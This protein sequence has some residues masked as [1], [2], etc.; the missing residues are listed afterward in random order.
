[1]SNKVENNCHLFLKNNSTQNLYLPTHLQ[2][3]YSN[4]LTDSSSAFIIAQLHSL[5]NN[6]NSKTKNK[7][8]LE[9]KNSNT[10]FSQRNLKEAEQMKKEVELLSNN[11]T[12]QKTVVNY[13]NDSNEMKE[14]NN[15]EL[16]NNCVK[17]INDIRKKVSK[18]NVQHS[19]K[20][21]KKVKSIYNG[22]EQSQGTEEGN[23][24][25]VKK[26][27]KL[28]MQKS[29]KSLCDK[30]NNNDRRIIKESENKNINKKDNK[31][32]DYVKYVNNDRYN[33][34]GNILNMTQIYSQSKYIFNQSK[35]FT[36]IERK[37]SMIDS[38]SNNQKND[39]ECNKSNHNFNY[40][41]YNK[42]KLGFI[43]RK[44]L[45]LLSKEINK[46]EC[47][48]NVNSFVSKNISTSPNSNK[49][50]KNY[51]SN[52]QKNNDLEKSQNKIDKTDDNFKEIKYKSNGSDK[53]NDSNK[54][55]IF[56]IKPTQ[57]TKKS[58]YKKNNEKYQINKDN[59]TIPSSIGS[60]NTKD[61]NKNTLD[62]I[63]DI[64]NKNVDNP[65]EL[66]FLYIKILQ[67]GKEISKKFEIESI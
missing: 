50:T 67:N 3:K 44:E 42:Y 11:K 47:N 5:N 63:S 17:D 39:N 53:N 59:K 62:S 33:V 14:N 40:I 60:T 48:N 52:M 56:F 13:S 25:M 58:P 55:N 61:I 23:N 41:N 21:S 57:Q 30:N 4:N 7:N 64:F 35:S 66:H 22:I 36:K 9:N 20:P 34:N 18:I 29:K 27:L 49:K 51:S 24:I 10:C 43:K 31:E 54:K 19:A 6:K 45:A 2:N 38:C 15:C 12:K 8:N 32:K 46:M 37:K 65:E 1:M 28:G 16:N 26:N